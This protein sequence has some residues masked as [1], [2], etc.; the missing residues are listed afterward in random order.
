MLELEAISIQILLE[1]PFTPDSLS[2]E[3]VS[4]DGE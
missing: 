4:A 3:E 1:N 2:Q